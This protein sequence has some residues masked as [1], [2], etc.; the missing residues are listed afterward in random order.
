MSM[1]R[2]RAIL[3]AAAIAGATAPAWG[4]AGSGDKLTGTSW[5]L[6]RYEDSNGTI[7]KP[8]DPARYT[9]TFQANG[10]LSARIDCNRGSGPWKTAGRS[11]LSL[12][13]LA[14]TRAK[15]PPGSLH[16]RIVKDWKYLRSYVVRKNHLFLLLMLDAGSYEFAPR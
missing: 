8:K 16:D 15:C 6:V 9:I 14:L 12:G 11:G 10:R 2:G 4:A 7:L 5:Q 13:P 3:L 1:K